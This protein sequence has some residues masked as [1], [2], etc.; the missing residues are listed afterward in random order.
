MVKKDKI[1]KNDKL[2]RM[3]K[4]V[5]MASICMEQVRKTIKKVSQDFQSE[6][7]PEP[8]TSLRITNIEC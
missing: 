4:A 5:V 6:P 3:R 8:R 7:I 1:I 2:E